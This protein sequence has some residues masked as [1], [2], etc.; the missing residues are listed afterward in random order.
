MEYLLCWGVK[1]LLPSSQFLT[2][3]NLAFSW[4]LLASG[5][6][7]AT[8]AFGLVIA[9]PA[10]QGMRGHRMGAFTINTTKDS[11]SMPLK[12]TPGATVTAATASFT[13]CS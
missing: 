8:Y 12:V 7:I 11:S 10:R 1:Y 9:T 5:S 6:E 13:G 4:I 3:G 2:T